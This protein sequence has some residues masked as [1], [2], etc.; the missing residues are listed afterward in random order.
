MKRESSEKIGTPGNHTL[1]IENIPKDV[2]LG[3]PIVTLTGNSEIVIENYRGIIEYTE[4]LIRIKRKGGEIKIIGKRL[5][6]SY[7]K[8]DDM[9]I[10]GEIKSLEYL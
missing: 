10:V 4:M 2:V 7:Y 5:Q 1:D 9:K 8:N 3:V 6:V